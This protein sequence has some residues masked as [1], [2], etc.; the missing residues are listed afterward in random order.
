MTANQIAWWNIQENI[1]SHMQNELN[2]R[3]KNSITQS[4]GEESNRINSS[5]MQNDFVLGRQG[6]EI[7]QQQANTASRKATQDYDVGLKTVANT[8]TRNK[9][10]YEIGTTSNKIK[11]QDVANNYIIGTATVKNQSI[12]NAQDYALGQLQQQSNAR[13]ADAAVL[14]A[15][16]ALGELNPAQMVVALT[17]PTA[18]R[19]VGRASDKVAKVVEKKVNTAIQNAKPVK[20]TSTKTKTVSPKVD[21]QRAA[22]SAITRGAVPVVKSKT[23]TKKEKTPTRAPIKGRTP[24]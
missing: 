16:V 7:S 20:S 18:Q 22:V 3:N 21:T 19:V 23:P 15:G 12:R 24:K 17:A 13:Q 6:N 9:Q 14:R 10:D 8:A 1:R 2:E 11:A 4:L 5:R